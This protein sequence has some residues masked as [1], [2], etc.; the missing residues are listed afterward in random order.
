MPGI[1]Q[2]LEVPPPVS[3]QTILYGIYQALGGSSGGG[4]IS[5][6]LTPR[7]IWVDATN[8]NNATGALGRMDKPFQTLAAAYAAGVTGGV[9]FALVFMPN[10]NPYTLT[11]AAD[12]SEFC[13]S[14]G[15]FGVAFGVA[16][17]VTPL[18][19]INVTATADEALNASGNAAFNGNISID[20]VWLTLT[21]NGQ[22]VVGDDDG[23]YTTGNGG[24]WTIRGNGF[25]TASSNGGEATAINATVINGGSG[26]ALTLLN[27]VKT[28]GDGVSINE[29]TGAGNGSNGNPGTLTA[30]N[31]DLRVQS[32]IPGGDVTL[33]RC[34]YTTG[35]IT[36]TNNKGG[37]AEWPT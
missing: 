12:L 14:F 7:I 34:S 25:L 3:V 18:V 27:G 37:N 24:N 29:A 32:I 22:A 26:G 13:V 5:S 20:G 10:S 19:R 11:L 36:I 28:W 30:D 1:P 9:N 16:D 31:C 2:T 4:V 23:T 33:G 35:A 15:A 17:G 21:A 6:I 8:G